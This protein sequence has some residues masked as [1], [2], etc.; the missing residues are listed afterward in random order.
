[1]FDYLFRAIILRLIRWLTDQI[2]KQL[3]VLDLESVDTN[4]R[5]NTIVFTDA[6]NYSKEYY[7]Y[8]TLISI[9]SRAFE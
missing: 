3:I 6:R 4:T 2:Y 1:M 7:L 5:S 9:L 8:R